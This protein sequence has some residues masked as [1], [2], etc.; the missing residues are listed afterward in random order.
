MK[1]KVRMA[2]DQRRPFGLSL[3]HP[4]LAEYPL[5]LSDDRLNRFGTERL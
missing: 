5:P 1:L 2:C 4:V 3:L